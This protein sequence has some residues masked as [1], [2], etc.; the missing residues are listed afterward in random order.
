MPRAA[1][2]FGLTPRERELAG[3]LGED[4]NFAEIAAQLGISRHTVNKH[5]LSIQAKLG[6]HS[7]H[8]AVALLSAL[9][10]P[11]LKSR[12]RPGGAGRSRSPKQN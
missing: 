2:P 3:W 7:R 8:A 10:I 4:V 9:G 1:S 5:C 11:V 6:V 12:P